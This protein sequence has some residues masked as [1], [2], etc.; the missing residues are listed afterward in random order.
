MPENL[1]E[2]REKLR[3]RIDF[4]RGDFTL[5]SGKKSDFYF[6]GK[7]TTLR[8]DALNY[9][10]RL[11]LD[12]MRPARPG[13]VG[14]MTLGADAMIGAV[15]AL[16]WDLGMPVEGFIV[17][18]EPKSHGTGQW[19]EGPELKAGERVAILEDVVTTGGS[20]VKAIE[21]VR[22]SCPAVVIVGVYALVD[23]LEGGRETL[24]KLAVPL[25]P[26]FTKDD[27]I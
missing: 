7:T 1:V 10:A 25:F 22:E 6:N 9:T 20:A 27:L 18:K 14:G 17:R 24:A 19:I 4:L 15:T 8:P 13:R 2:F 16:S 26:L 23:R 3:G 5:A 11:L 21:R 12:L